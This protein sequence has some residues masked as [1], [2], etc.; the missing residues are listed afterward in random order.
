[1]KKIVV[2]V[3]LE[4]KEL[5][6]LKEWGQM[7]D[8]NIISEVTFLHVVH[9]VATPMEFALV[10]VPDQ[11]SYEKMK[12]ELEKFLQEQVKTITPANFKGKAETIVDIS[13]EP[14]ETVID[15]L[16]ANKTDLVVA[17]TKGKKGFEGFFH[18]SF[19]E[20]LIKFGPCD[21]Y[22]VKPKL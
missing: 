9:R 1:M 19:T 7:F 12:P 16:K 6:T 3:P 18:H 11:E 20:H 14:E 21:V 17:A 13:F 15:F 2:T 22:V 4:E 5:A 10:E 8:W